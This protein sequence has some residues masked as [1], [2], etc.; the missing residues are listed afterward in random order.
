VNQQDEV[1][2]RRIAMYA[3]GEVGTN[4]SG[5]VRKIVDQPATYGIKAGRGIGVMFLADATIPK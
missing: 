5:E 3:L 2:G 4:A 1:N